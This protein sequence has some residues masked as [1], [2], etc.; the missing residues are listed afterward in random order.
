MIYSG[1]KY[2][3]LSAIKYIVYIVYDFVRFFIVL[4]L[5]IVLGLL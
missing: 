5:A 4:Y 2:S 1:R 3:L